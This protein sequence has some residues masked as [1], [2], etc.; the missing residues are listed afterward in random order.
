MD[1]NATGAIVEGRAIALPQ[2][3]SGRGRLPLSWRLGQRR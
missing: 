2:A 3:A 1:R